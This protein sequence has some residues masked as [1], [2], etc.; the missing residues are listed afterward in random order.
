MK[1]TK[2]TKK[3]QPIHPFSVGLAWQ[4]LLEATD[5]ISQAVLGFKESEKTNLMSSI[6]RLSLILRKNP[7]SKEVQKELN[8]CLNR[9]S[10][11]Y[12]WLYYH[13]NR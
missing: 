2:H 4:H 11:Q 10:K 12:D 5:I 6:V 9:Y 1:K 13:E 8:D 7:K 3:P